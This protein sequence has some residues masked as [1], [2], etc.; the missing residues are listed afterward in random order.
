MTEEGRK[1]VADWLRKQAVWLEQDGGAY[2]PRFVAR[3]GYNEEEVNN[4]ETLT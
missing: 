4:K 2:S 3:Y 1:D